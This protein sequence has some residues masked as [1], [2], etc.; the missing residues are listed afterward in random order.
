MFYWF[1][2][3]D[4]TPG[5][6][7]IHIQDSKLCVWVYLCRQYAGLTLISSIQQEAHSGA[8]VLQVQVSQKAPLKLCLHLVPTGSTTALQENHSRLAQ[9]PI[10]QLPHAC[11]VLIGQGL[12]SPEAEMQHVSCD[13]G[14]GAL[15]RK[16]WL[17]IWIWILQ[18]SSWF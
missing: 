14:T 7:S 9:Q 5:S 12:P 2:K 10:S 6:Q 8:Q 18:T 15:W 17:T 13:T 1:L 16:T 4:L 3:Q 11:T